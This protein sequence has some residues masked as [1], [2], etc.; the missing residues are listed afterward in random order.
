M[1]RVSP[2]APPGAAV[3]Y[4]HVPP[5]RT[6]LC[7]HSSNIRHTGA[8]SPH[9]H[10]L[11]GV[12]RSPHFTD[13]E[14]ELSAF[15]WRGPSF[16]FLLPERIPVPCAPQ[17]P[18]SP[19]P[20]LPSSLAQALPAPPAPLPLAGAWL[21]SGGDVPRAPIYVCP[22]T[23]L[24]SSPLAL[25]LANRGFCRMFIVPHFLLQLGRGENRAPG[26]APAAWAAVWA[27]SCTDE[28]PHTGSVKSAA[29][30][31]FTPR[32]LASAASQGFP[33]ES[34]LVTFPTATLQGA[35]RLPFLQFVC[36]CTGPAFSFRL[37]LPLGG[38]WGGGGNLS[39]GL[40]C[41]HLA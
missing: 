22:C 21:A 28:Q 23:W 15:S 25:S 8:L 34:W 2:R 14:P 7:S 26:G 27:P 19:H 35:A 38:R 36:F 10:P 41:C 4:R 11:Q 12:W 31:A 32:A 24:L 20:G 16:A 39:M 5:T 33:P 1:S 13:E 37:P 17:P 29:V 40:H 9:D 30:G 6:A 18:S 3:T